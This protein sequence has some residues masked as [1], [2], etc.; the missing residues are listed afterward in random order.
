LVTCQPPGWDPGYE[1][2]KLSEDCLYLNV[3]VPHRDWNDRRG[4][5]RPMFVWIHGGFTGGA[6]QDT[7][8]RKYVEQSGAVYVTINY[9]LGAIGFLNL[10]QLREEGDGA[11]A[12]GLLDQQAAL[13]WIQ[14][15]ISRF[16]GDRSN[17]TIAGQSAGGSSVCDQLASPTARGL[18]HRAV[19]QS[20][21]C[22]MTS[23]ADADRA[24][25]AYL[26][27]LGCTDP[28]GVLECLRGK[29]SAEL[30]TA[31]QRSPIG[32]RPSVG[33]RS[34]PI[35][36]G[37]AVRSGQ[38][39]RVPVISGQVDNERAL[40]AFQNND[41]VG[42]PI[43]AEGYEAM[44]RDTYGANAVSSPR[45]RSAPTRRRAT[46]G[47]SCSPTRSRTR[48]SRPSGGSR[49]G[50]GRTSTS[51]TRRRR[52]SSSRSSACSGSASPP[53]RSRSAR[54]TWTSLRTCG[55]TSAP[56]CRLPTTSSSSPTR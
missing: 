41:Y 4:G 49:S 28:T 6:G 1:Q 37:V 12:F 15:N 19:I 11:R 26:E 38:F 47:D 54:R 40:F 24:G 13:R 29:S 5:K 34:F 22:A 2:N 56:R 20:G 17:V 45:T 43:T 48:G 27:T 46:R 33:S 52:R 36:P 32:I 21:S 55:S 18:F 44:I 3:Y 9:R 53:G 7:D 42:R 39:N 10:P 16:G 35:D 14:R 8:P 23:Q 30:L 25:Q 50:R 51:S 31:Q